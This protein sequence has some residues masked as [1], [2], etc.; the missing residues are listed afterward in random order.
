MHAATF[1]AVVVLPTPPFWLA[2][3]YTVPIRCKLAPIAPL[4]RH[5]RGRQSGENGVRSCGAVSPRAGACAPCPRG[6]GSARASSPTFA[7]TCRWWSRAPANGRDAADL[8]Q[9]QPELRRRAVAAA[10]SSG[11]AAPAPVHERR[12]P[13]AAAAPRTRARPAAAPAP[14]PRRDRCARAP[15][16]PLLRAGA[17]H[18]ARS[19]GPALAAAA[20]RNAHF[21]ALLSTSATRL[22][23]ARPRAASPGK[24]APAAEVGDPARGADR[25]SSSS[26]HERV[27]EV[28]VDRPRRG[29]ATAV[30][31]CSSRLERSRA[32]RRAAPA[33]ARSGRGAPRA[34]RSRGSASSAGMLAKKSA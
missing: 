12:R 2:I 1:T 24:P 23:A 17:H 5:C 22:R 13:A 32:A 3:A 21:R 8:R 15:S 30:G 18:R 34:R 20:S 28:D 33:G 19:P 4:A 11:V 6:A 7:K 27:G 31:A 14:A 10:S 25:R 9:L 16:L 29:V 26:A